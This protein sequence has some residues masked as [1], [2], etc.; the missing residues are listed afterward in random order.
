MANTIRT[1]PSEGFVRQRELLAH[2]PFSKST[3]W[4]M[5]ASGEFPSP[6]KLSARITA[7][8][9]S[10]VRHWIATHERKQSV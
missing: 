7:W 10:A 3:L 8:S 6:V 1:L 9:V 4:K 5:V 2:V